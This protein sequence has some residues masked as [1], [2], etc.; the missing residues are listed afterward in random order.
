MGVKSGNKCHR[1][2]DCSRANITNMVLVFK[3]VCRKRKPF[4]PNHKIGYNSI[5][6]KTVQQAEI[7]LNDQSTVI[8][9][10]LDK[11]YEQKKQESISPISRDSKFKNKVQVGNRLGEGALKV[12]SYGLPCHIQM[13]TKKEEL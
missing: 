3:L 5:A 9:L 8:Q 10:R 4:V 6:L 12:S 2:T 1:V 7:W 11:M 13:E